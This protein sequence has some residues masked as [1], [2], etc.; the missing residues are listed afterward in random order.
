MPIVSGKT[1]KNCKKK[2]DLIAGGGGIGVT[3]CSAYQD[4]AFE[5]ALRPHAVA[6]L[7]RRIKEQKKFIIDLGVS[8][9]DG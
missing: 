7:E 2:R 6:E 1:F 9:P 8:F 5:D 4:A 3:I